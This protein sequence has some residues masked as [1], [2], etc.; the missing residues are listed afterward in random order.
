MASAL[1]W[2]RDAGGRQVRDG[3]F[4]S[5]ETGTLPRAQKA[6]RPPAVDEEEGEE[7]PL[8][9]PPSLFLFTSP[10]QPSAFSLP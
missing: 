5:R 3:L 4:S 8:P 6:G 2:M 9:P 1:T 7:L 10:P